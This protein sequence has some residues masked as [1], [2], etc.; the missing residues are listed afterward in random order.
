SGPA[1]ALTI[2][3]FGHASPPVSR[4]GARAGD[5]IWVT[6]SLGAARAALTEWLAGRD[7][8][9]G[10]RLAFTRPQSRHAAAL[11]LRGQGVTAMMDVSDGLAGDVPHLAAA[12]GLRFEIDIAAVP[13][14]PAVH[15]VAARAGES[16][17]RFATTGGE[18]Y[19]LLLTLPA[20]SAAASHAEP[21]CGVT[22]TRIGTVREGSGAV[23]LENGNE[24]ML[25]GFRHA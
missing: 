14:H 20:S 13:V 21:A 12:S 16:A 4:R 10:A 1:L 24:V 17:R 11:W 22:L 7:P 2:T 9:P 23:F 6:G 18:D 15:A 5:G 3:A 8:A 19:E 25:R